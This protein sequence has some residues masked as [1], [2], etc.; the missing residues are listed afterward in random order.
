MSE[1]SFRNIIEINKHNFNELCPYDPLLYE[2]EI[3]VEWTGTQI[4]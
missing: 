1:Y 3:L 2:L 4:I